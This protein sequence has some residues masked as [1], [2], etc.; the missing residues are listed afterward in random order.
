MPPEPIDPRAE[1]VSPRAA[2]PAR[3][4]SRAAALRAGV[5]VAVLYSLLWLFLRPAYGP[6]W[7]AILGEYPY[8]ETFLANLGSGTWDYVEL[9]RHF[10][11]E[12]GLRQPHPD[13]DVGRLPWIGTYPLTG[14][15][16]A[17]S[18]RVFWTELGWLPALTAHDLAILPSLAALLVAMTAVLARR[19]GLATALSAAFF[20]LASPRFFADAFN[21][22]K[23]VPEAALYSLTLL[24]LWAAVHGR[25]RRAWAASGVLLALSLAQRPNAF[26]LPLQFGLFLAGAAL[27]RRRTGRAPLAWSWSGLLLASLLFFVAYFAVSPMLWTDTWARL[28]EW[29]AYTF[30]FN[31]FLGD[32]DLAIQAVRGPTHVST[33]AARLVLL[34]TPLPLLALA[35]VGL[36]SREATFEERWFLLLGAAVPVGRTL[37]PGF[38]HY[39]GVRHFLEFLPPLAVLAALG[40]STCV[41]LLAG[42]GPAL[43]AARAAAFGLALLPGV[44]ASAATHPNGI[45]YFNA[46][47]GGLSGAQARG[48]LDATDYWGNSYWQAL[49]WLER[50]AEP[51]ATVLVPIAPHIVLAAAPVKLRSDLRVV[52]SPADELSSAGVLYV[53][54]I[55]RRGL[56]C[57]LLREVDGRVAPVHE[58]RVQDAPILRILRFEGAE[59]ERALA[60][61]AADEREFEAGRRLLRWLRADPERLARALE[62]VNRLPELGEEH[63]R[64]ELEALVTPEL[65]G[66]VPRLIQVFGR[67]DGAQLVEQP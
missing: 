44:L 66:E 40:L 55:T 62:L 34:T 36:V 47:A 54:Y 30:G 19:F 3:G 9:T 46:L 49:G 5:C 48:I 11:P 14:F 4:V 67:R 64:R 20:L 23:D 15:L 18:C 42:P 35:L 32:P 13:F 38:P 56:Y 51:E 63:V 57:S 2:L 37:I 33:E 8:G 24:A 59:A 17:L 10:G 58:I 1:L 53:V 61:W 65:R 26:F 31:T 50:R 28:R 12:L 39:D 6:T 43:R 25:G 41:R 60:T 27:W 22:L 7:D 52:R 29:S 45:C 21:N 16:S